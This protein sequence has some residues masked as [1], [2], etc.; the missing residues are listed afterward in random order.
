MPNWLMTIS[1]LVVDEIDA[2]DLAYSPSG[3]GVLMFDGAFAAV[4][5]ERRDRRILARQP[6]RF[7]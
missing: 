3:P 1:S 6:T 7:S 2:G 5:P 4:R